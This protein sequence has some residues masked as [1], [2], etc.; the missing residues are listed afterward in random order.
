MISTPKPLKI[1]VIREIRDSD[2]LVSIS[3]IQCH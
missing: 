2:A 1:R 3:K